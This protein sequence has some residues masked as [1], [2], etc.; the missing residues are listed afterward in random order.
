MGDG[1]FKALQGL[2]MREDDLALYSNYA[3]IILSFGIR[4]LKV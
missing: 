1:I 4:C 3:F 2:S